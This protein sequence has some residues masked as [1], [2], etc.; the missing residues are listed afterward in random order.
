M[1][2]E[3]T[4]MRVSVLSTRG[5]ITVPAALRKKLRLIPGTLISLSEQ[6]GR[7]VLTPIEQLLDEILGFL[8]PQPGEPSAFEASLEERKRARRREKS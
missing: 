7:L 1:A 8:K 4:K 5:R 2:V 3:M 6:D